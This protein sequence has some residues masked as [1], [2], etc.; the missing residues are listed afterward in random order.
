MYWRIDNFHIFISLLLRAVR[1]SSAS[2]S[3]TRETNRWL[4]S[5]ALSG[6]GG[7]NDQM[8][9]TLVG[10][11]TVKNEMNI[12]LEM[13]TICPADHIQCF[14]KMS[15]FQVQVQ[16]QRKGSLPGQRKA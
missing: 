3:S 8:V 11:P 5:T 2:S 16:D 10:R 12:A 1:S 7:N 9:I 14:F 6:P 15:I 13:L 4:T